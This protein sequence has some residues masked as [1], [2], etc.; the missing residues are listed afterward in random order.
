MIKNIPI[1]N[2]RNYFNQNFVIGSFFKN[3]FEA[4]LI[5]KTTVVSPGKMNFSVFCNFLSDEVE[6]IFW[7]SEK[8]KCSKLFKSKFGHL[9]LLIKWFCSYL[10]LK[11]QS[12]QRFKK[13]FFKFSQIFEWRSWHDFLEKWSKLFRT[14]LIKN[15]SSEAS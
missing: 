14:I 5:W 10:E 2:L 9:K 13:P 3:A 4:T 12:S 1:R 6:S 11:N 7:E 15:W 8:A